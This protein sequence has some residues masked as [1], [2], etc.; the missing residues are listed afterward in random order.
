MELSGAVMMLPER[1]WA[2]EDGQQ[3]EWIM[4]K[5]AKGGGGPGVSLRQAD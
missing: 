5:V 2:D 4:K 3:P 1:C